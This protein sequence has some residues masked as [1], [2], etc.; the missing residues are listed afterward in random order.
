MKIQVLTNGIVFRW[1]D[2]YADD[3]FVKSG[4]II[5]RKK[6][7]DRARWGRV[8]AI[9][10]EVTQVAVGEYIMPEKTQQPFGAL[11]KDEYDHKLVEYWKTYESDIMLVTDDIK[12]TYQT[13]DEYE[14][15]KMKPF[16]W[17]I[18]PA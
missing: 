18:T 2:S 13:N 5:T 12:D 6:D 17:D 15:G 7:K 3:V 1:L 8:L 16:G 9:G 14:V 11:V 10:P 4:L